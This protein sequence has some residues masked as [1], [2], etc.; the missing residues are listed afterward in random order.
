MSA[1]CGTNEW[2]I[3]E[4][5]DRGVPRFIED[6]E[7][8]ERQG[9]NPDVCKAVQE[10]LGDFLSGARKIETAALFPSIMDY[11][12]GFR[13][14]YV[15]WNGNE[16]R[17]D[18]DAVAARRDGIEELRATRGEVKSHY[19]KRLRS[20]SSAVSDGDFQVVTEAYSQF[21][22]LVAKQPDLFIRLKSSVDNF[23]NRS[24][25]P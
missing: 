6:L 5:L 1:R 23:D 11:W 14:H 25:H 2:S 13:D 12:V 17:T 22:K 20:G 8:V 15:R 7:A 18:K 3:E 19:Q 16:K 21:R 10:A 24:R 4:L 9:I